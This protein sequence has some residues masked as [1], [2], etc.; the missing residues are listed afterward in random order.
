[1]KKEPRKAESKKKDRLEK[2]GATRESQSRWTGWS[3]PWSRQHEASTHEVSSPSEHGKLDAEKKEDHG[4]EAAGDDIITTTLPSDGGGSDEYFEQVQSD[5]HISYAAEGDEKEVITVCQQGHELKSVEEPFPS[6]LLGEHWTT[7]VDTSI[8]IDDEFQKWAERKKELERNEKAQV[9]AGRKIFEIE[10]AKVKQDMANDRNK[11]L[12]E[13]KIQTAEEIQKEKNDLSKRL[14]AAKVAK[15]ESQNI[16]YANIKHEV[17]EAEANSREILQFERT[18]IL[19]EMEEERRKRLQKLEMEMNEKIIKEKKLTVLEKLENEKQISDAECK[20]AFE[21]QQARIREEMEHDRAKK[22]QEIENE[23]TEV[24]KKEKERSN[25]K[26]QSIQ[27]KISQEKFES[28]RE[29]AD[30]IREQ[31]SKEKEAQEIFQKEEHEAN[32]RLRKEKVQQDKNFEEKKKKIIEASK[33][34]EAKLQKQQE[35]RAILEIIEED[36]MKLQA[37]M[38]LAEQRKKA[39]ETIELYREE[40]R[41][42]AR[43]KVEDIYRST[44]ENLKRN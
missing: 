40:E 7:N 12:S 44:H 6:S 11:R 39:A 43:V 35:E 10:K 41:E 5:R 33:E 17:P 20:Q 9:E 4:R 23:M 31:K 42:K 16:P 13:K 38:E 15:E 18:K 36:E 14:L 25:K 29:L 37:L 26:L 27:T 34:Q 2:V 3:M 8:N 1:M 30:F 28:K 24:M 22:L 21:F 19:Q 32:E